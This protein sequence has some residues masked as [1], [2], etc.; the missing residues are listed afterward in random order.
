MIGIIGHERALALIGAQL[1][2]AGI[3]GA[4]QQIRH[5]VWL[6]EERGRKPEE[7]VVVRRAPF[8]MMG[9]DA[10]TA[11]EMTLDLTCTA[12]D[13]LE[14]MDRPPKARDQGK[15]WDKKR[16]SKKGRSW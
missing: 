9:G 14:A 3:P 5:V 13:D 11:A 12:T 4:V 6:Y 16:G 15:W 2:A 1:A 8:G 7:E 10:A